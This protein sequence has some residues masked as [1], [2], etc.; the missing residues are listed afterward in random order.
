MPALLPS[1]SDARGGRCALDK[2][3]WTLHLAKSIAFDPFPPM[4]RPSTNAGVDASHV[5]RRAA[6]APANIGSPIHERT[7]SEA[8]P[9]RIRALGHAHH[10][11]FTYALPRAL[12]TWEIARGEGMVAP[13]CASIQ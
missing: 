3:F 13:Q 7:N 9:E 5:T 11:V 8:I 6:L 10:A 12:R 4:K 1:S 2:L